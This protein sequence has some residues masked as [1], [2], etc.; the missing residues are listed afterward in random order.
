MMIDHDNLKKQ[1]E[2]GNIKAIKH[3]DYALTIYD[4]TMQATIENVWTPEER[5]ARGL[6]L[7]Y[8]GHVVARPFPKF[9]NLGERDECKPENLPGE[10]PE[11]ADKMDGSLIIVW[12]NPNGFWDCSTRGSFQSPQALRGKEFFKNKFNTKGMLPWRTYLFEYVGPENQIVVRYEREAFYFLGSVDNVTGVDWSYAEA[13]GWA[14][15][16]G[17]FSPNFQRNPIDAIDLSDK[18]VKNFEG[19]VARFSN[20]YRVKLKY[21]EYKLL[22]RMVTG[23]SEKA[24]WEGL[25]TGKELDAEKLPDEFLKW[26]R[27][28]RDSLIERFMIVL[29]ISN[30]YHDRNAHKTRK[31]YAIGLNQ[32]DP[33]VR[34]AAFRLLDGQNPDEV[35]WNSLKPVNSKSKFQE[36][37]AT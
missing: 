33:A 17:H 20:G 2:K 18:T 13:R 11:M 29:R 6:I 1:V 27:Q 10:T 4:Y 35:I 24:I 34:A 30:M 23:L 37:M 8:N 19:Y 3:P 36:N 15:A 25:A 16:H 9:F 22:H 26:Y 14:E 32:Y 31:E 7:D 5:M 21:D 12:F 28:K